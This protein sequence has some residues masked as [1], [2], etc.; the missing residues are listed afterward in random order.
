MFRE[1]MT[2]IHSVTVITCFLLHTSES[3]CRVLVPVTVVHVGPVVAD[4]VW[5][6]PRVLIVDKT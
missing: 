5:A 1:M 6:G 4:E 2:V 3:E